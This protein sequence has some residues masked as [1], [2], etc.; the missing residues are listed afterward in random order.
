LNAAWGKHN[1]MFPATVGDELLQLLGFGGIS[2]NE[3]NG[4]VILQDFDVL[5]VPDGLGQQVFGT[6]KW[7]WFQ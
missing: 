2:T 7:L 3:D 6:Y 5:D 1:F 4:G